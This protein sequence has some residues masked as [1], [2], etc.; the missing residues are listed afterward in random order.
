M[1]PTM[2]TYIITTTHTTHTSPFHP[3]DP[4]PLPPSPPSI[5]FTIPLHIK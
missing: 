2:T 4:S 5:L 1:C 3:T